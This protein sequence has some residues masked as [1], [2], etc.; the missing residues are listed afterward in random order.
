VFIERG[1][2][3]ASIEQIAKQ[4]QLSVGAIYLYFQSKEDLH[5]LILETSLVERHPA[6][7]GPQV[8]RGRLADA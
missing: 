8:M 2:A 7:R 6:R 1:F 4:A 5:V 3:R